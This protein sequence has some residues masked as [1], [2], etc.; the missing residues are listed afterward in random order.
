[1]WAAMGFVP[2][3]SAQ[4]LGPWSQSSPMATLD[5]RLSLK[6]AEPMILPISLVHNEV[7]LDLTW[8]RFQGSKGGKKPVHVASSE[9]LPKRYSVT[10]F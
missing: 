3:A 10:T 2:I 8:P 7:Q 5:R 4:A 1:M 9:K 6:W